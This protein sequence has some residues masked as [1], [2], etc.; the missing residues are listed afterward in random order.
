[1]GNLS[2]AFD[3]LGCSTCK[4]KDSSNKAVRSVGA[5]KTAPATVDWSQAKQHK[6]QF[7]ALN[8]PGQY[9]YKKPPKINKVTGPISEGINKVKKNPQLYLGILFQTDMKGWPEDQQR[10]DLVL[11]NG[12]GYQFVA[13]QAHFTFIQ[14]NYR[15]LKPYNEISLEPDQYTDKMSYGGYRCGKPLHPG[16][17]QGLCDLPNIKLIGDVHP[18]D[19]A[20]GGVGDCWLLCAA[21]ALSEFH[22]AVRK[23]FRKTPYLERLPLDEPQLYTVTLY[24]MKTWKPVD[25]EVDERL[26]TSPDSSGI[27][28]CHPCSQGEL[29]ACYLEKAM[30]IHCGGWD[31]INGGEPTHAWRMLTG[32]KYQ[33]TFSNEGHGYEC[34]GSF[35][36]N[37]NEWEP[38]ENAYHKCRSVMWPMKWPELGGG[39]AIGFKCGPKEMFQR[40][41]AWDAQNYMMALGTRQGSNSKSFNG[42]VDGHAYTLLTCLSNVAGS[43]QDLVKVRNPW[44]QGECTSSLWD[45]NGHG[46]DRFP[47][48]REACQPVTANDGVFWLSSDEMFKYFPTIYLCAMDMKQFVK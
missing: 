25:V 39:G 28:G 20:Q 40:M 12:S 5:L 10:Y 31:Q 34:F 21:S 2:T 16:R 45:D 42:I 33:Y 17:G 13:G 37:K 7:D 15:A 26:C 32:C 1:M 14:A 47:E 4:P 41:C 30:A 29:W 35:N 38:L 6:W 3:D 22:G 19:V 24:D 23:V 8:G 43:G 36:P 18:D 44:G 11:R 46:W 9:T 27:L 48:V